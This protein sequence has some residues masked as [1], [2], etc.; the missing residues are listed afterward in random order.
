MVKQIFKKQ[1]EKIEYREKKIFWVLFSVFVFFI[2]SYGFL[3][4]SIMMHSSL[5]ENM[6]KE[7]ISFG[8]EVNSL[9]FQYLNIKNSITLDLA[10]SKGFVS[11]S[12]DK[13]AL[14]D[15]TQ[16]NLS[17]SINEN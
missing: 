5:K 10:K 14:I 3:L 16:K 7:I 8:S 17:L 1:I 9:E 15:S 12:A 4:T 13:F 2:V 11:V 6:G